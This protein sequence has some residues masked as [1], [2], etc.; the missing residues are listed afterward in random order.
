M[1]FLGLLADSAW[2]TAIGTL[3]GSV[4]TFFITK[5]NN[6][7]DLSINDR[8]Q[9]S[10]DQYQL[11]AELRQMMQEQRDEIEVLREEIK[12]LQAV[13]ISLIIENKELQQK[14]AELNIKLT[15]LKQ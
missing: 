1:D 5:S 14:I 7:K 6:K 8:M 11:I 13:N 10:K 12:Q 9:L 3:L 4:V 2:I 15:N